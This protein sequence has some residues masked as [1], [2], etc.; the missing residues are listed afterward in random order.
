MNTAWWTLRGSGQRAHH[1]IPALLAGMPVFEQGRHTGAMPGRLIQGA[2]TRVFRFGKSQ[3]VSSV[4]S[5]Q[6]GLLLPT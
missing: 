4:P 1:R 3:V 5:R 6:I 2:L